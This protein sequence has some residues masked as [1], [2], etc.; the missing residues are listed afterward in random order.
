MLAQQEHA[1]L[2]IFVYTWLEVLS[3]IALHYAIKRELGFSPARVLSF[4]LENQFFLGR[5]VIWYLIIPDFNLYHCG[6]LCNVLGAS[7]CSYLIPA[8]PALI[9]YRLDSSFPIAARKTHLD[10]ATY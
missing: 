10:S 7:V 2:N 3:F 6:K 9:R 1:M 4:V 5:L 8:L